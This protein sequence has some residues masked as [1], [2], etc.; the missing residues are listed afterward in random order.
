MPSVTL[1]SDFICPYCYLGERAAAPALAALGLELDWRGFEIHP[2]TPPGGVPAEVL[3]RMGLGGRWRQ[4][5]AQAAAVGVPIARPPRLSWSRLA[6]E[7]AEMARREGRLSD[8]RDRVFRAY[9]TEGA[10]IADVN[11]LCGLAA[12]AGLDRRGFAEALRARRFREDVDRHREEAEDLLVTGVPAFFLHGVPVVGAQST[13]AYQR[14]FARIL[15][16]RA[17]RRDAPPA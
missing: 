5:E 4:I 1:F 3:A 13:E 14:V 16:R 10:D 2:E 9:F 17:A 8:Y 11:S 12:D 15:A 7:G 6:L